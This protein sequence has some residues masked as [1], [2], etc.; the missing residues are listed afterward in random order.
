M[1]ALLVVRLCV[2]PVLLWY[3]AKKRKGEKQQKKDPA[4]AR[5]KGWAEEGEAASAAPRVP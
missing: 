1:M 5:G 3:C 4:A 2:C